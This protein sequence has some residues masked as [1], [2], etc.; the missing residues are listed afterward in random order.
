LHG[1]TYLQVCVCMQRDLVLA[2]TAFSVHPR[3]SQLA[4]R[5]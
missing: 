4:G 1:P 2:R 5:E 3:G